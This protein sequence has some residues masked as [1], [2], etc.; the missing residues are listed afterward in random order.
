MSYI[1][2]KK[3]YYISSFVIIWLLVDYFGDDRL[4]MYNDRIINGEL[5]L[6]KDYELKTEI[7]SDIKLVISLIIHSFIWLLVLF[8][9]MLL[10]VWGHILKII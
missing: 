3:I 6:V 8:T 10:S 1:L 5:V 7:V 4:W 2:N 9:Y